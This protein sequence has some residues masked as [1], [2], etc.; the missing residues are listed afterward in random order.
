MTLVAAFPEQPD[1]GNGLLKAFLPYLGLRPASAEDVLVEVLARPDAEKE[2]SFHHRR[3]GGGGV[4]DDG[5]MHARHR[6]RGRRVVRRTSG[7]VVAHEHAG[8]ASSGL[9]RCIRRR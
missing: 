3:R 5:R 8:S 1:D 7:R 2:A 6:E 9:T 4:G